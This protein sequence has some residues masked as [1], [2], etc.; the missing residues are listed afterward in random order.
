MI[1]FAVHCTL[2]SY[3]RVS[4]GVGMPLCICAQHTS[5]CC[6][7]FSPSIKWWQKLPLAFLI[8][9]NLGFWK[10]AGN[11]KADSMAWKKCRKR[12]LSNRSFFPIFP[13]HTHS[14]TWPDPLFPISPFLM[15]GHDWR[16]KKVAGISNRKIQEW[17]RRVTLCHLKG[18]VN[19]IFSNF[20]LLSLNSKWKSSEKCPILGSSPNLYSAKREKIR[21]G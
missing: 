15:L 21:V 2:V 6:D 8:F 11:S 9:K 1:L 7:L 3:Q 19:I 20:L 4:L 17:Y 5:F 14:Q 18:K 16:K 10:P 12:K 13:H